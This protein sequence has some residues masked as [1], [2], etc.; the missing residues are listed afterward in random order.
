M[1]H[2]RYRNGRFMSVQESYAMETR[3]LKMHI[4]SLII[5]IALGIVSEGRQIQV[6]VP[7]V[8]AV[9]TVQE[10]RDLCELDSVIC[11]HEESVERALQQIPHTSN[12]TSDVIRY[13]YEQ[14]PKHGVNPDIVAH[15]AWCESEFWNIQSRVFYTFTDP[16]RGIVQNAR[17]KSFGI[18]MIHTPD[19]NVTQDQALDQYFSVDWAITKIKKNAFVWYA[20]D[21]KSDSCTNGVKEYWHVGQ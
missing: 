6:L 10:E 9:E 14:A 18:F 20:Y 12:K 3:R 5:A 1:K 19:H 15:V 16:T 2:K 8:S 11:E 17:E 13:I 7:E 21:S 4:A